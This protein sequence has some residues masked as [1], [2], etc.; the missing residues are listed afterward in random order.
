MA[1]FVTP[2]AALLLALPQVALAAEPVCLTPREFTAMST[3]ALPS[4]IEGAAR[5]CATQLPES[6]FLRRSGTELAERYG[7]S[8]DRAW[9]EARAAFIKMSGSRDQGAA[10]LLAIMPEDSLKDMADAA[11][12]GIVA[13]QI[14]PGSCAT[15]DRIVALLSPLPAENTAELIALAAGLGAKTGEARV[16]KFALCKV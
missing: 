15:I 3:Y 16:G 7:A 9:P 4:L 1:R 10:Q 6:A 11:F 8:K 14:K 5:T 2:I 13:G 12:T